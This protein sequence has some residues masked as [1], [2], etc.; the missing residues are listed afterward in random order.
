MSEIIAKNDRFIL[1]K[2]EASD[3]KFFDEMA[4]E[5]YDEEYKRLPEK[6]RKRIFLAKYA[7]C[8]YLFYIFKQRQIL[9]IY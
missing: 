3:R 5:K 7:C 9:R 6:Y 4:R 8:Q 2:L 1:K